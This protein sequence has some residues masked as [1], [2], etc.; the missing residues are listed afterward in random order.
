MENANKIF[1]AITLEKFKG[2][3]SITSNEIPKLEKNKILVKVIYA[4]IQPSDLFLIQGQYGSSLPKTPFTPGGEA[5]GI[6]EKVGENLDSSLI[7][8]HIAFFANSSGPDFMGTWG[9]YCITNIESSIIFNSKIS[10][11]KI[12]ATMGNPITAMGFVDTIKKAGKNS[13]AHNGAS[14]TFGR[15]F[16]KLC[17][18]QGIEVINIVRKEE[19]VKELTELGGKHFIDTSKTNWKEDLTKMCIELKVDILFDCVGGEKTGQ[20]FKCLPE[21]SILY[22]FGNLA[23]KRLSDID[24]TDLI[25]KQKSIEGWWLLTWLLTQDKESLEACKQKII[26][27]FEENDGKIFKTDF[28]TKFDLV[29]YEKALEN[30]ITT[31]KKVVLSMWKN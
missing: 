12:F 30:Y 8:K 2:K 18:D 20:C 25:F 21:N 23:M 19:T 11:E 3:L 13:V 16:M 15:I 9:Q 29:D 7:G 24:T 22:H 1:N 4:T 27:D 26:K 5:C 6:I 31:G 17:L 28:T 14:S 10:F